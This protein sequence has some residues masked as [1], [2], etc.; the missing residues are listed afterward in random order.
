MVQPAQRKTNIPDQVRELE[1]DEL[2]VPSN[3][4]LSVT[5]IS[6]LPYYARV[7]HYSITFPQHL[8]LSYPVFGACVISNNAF[9]TS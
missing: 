8:L 3:P 2:N 5:L 7:S 1:P 9:L 6:E 4:S